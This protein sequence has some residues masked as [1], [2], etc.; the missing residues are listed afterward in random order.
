MSYRC[1]LTLTAANSDELI[2][3]DEFQPGEAAREA[4][5]AAAEDGL[6]D[7]PLGWI[8]VT[9]RR[10]VA[11]PAFTRLREAKERS[12]EGQLMQAVPP[13]TAGPDGTPLTDEQRAEIRDVAIRPTVDALFF[14][15]ES[16]TPPW[17]TEEATVVVAPPDRVAAAGAAWGEIAGRLGLPA[18]GA[19]E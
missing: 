15:L 8:E 5:Q 1:T 7:L 14:A 9:V 11:N 2:D 17:L 4:F 13:G 16:K 6:D 10:R 19:G 18:F 12:I 3:G